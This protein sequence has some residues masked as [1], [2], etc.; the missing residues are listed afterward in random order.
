MIQYKAKLLGIPVS[1]VEP[2]YTSQNCSMCGHLGNRNGKSF[3]CPSCGHV[4]HADSNASFNIAL[5]QIKDGRLDVD[6]DAFKGSTD[7]PQTAMMGT[8]STVE[9]H[10]L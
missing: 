6:R 2:A 9:P 10:V 7:T 5:R 1:Y 8:T 3:K 4:D